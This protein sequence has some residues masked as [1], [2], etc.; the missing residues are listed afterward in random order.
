MGTALA[1]FAG[2]L[3]VPIYSINADLGVPFLIKSFLALMTGG[4]G[5]FEG[6]AV[7]AVLIG[8]ATSAGPWFMPPVLAEILV[9]LAAIILVKLFPG[10]LVWARRRI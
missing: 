1:G 2:G 10:G 3:I 8:S 4:I 6:A 5:S 9:F 7:G